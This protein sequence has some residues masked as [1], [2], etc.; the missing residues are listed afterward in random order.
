MYALP[1]VHN[2]TR[3]SPELDAPVVEE[4]NNNVKDPSETKGPMYNTIGFYLD[5]LGQ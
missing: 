4:S 5:F 3:V 1:P 2:Q